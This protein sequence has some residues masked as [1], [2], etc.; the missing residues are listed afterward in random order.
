VVKRIRPTIFDMERVTGFS[1]GTISRAFNQTLPIKAETR[2]FILQKAKEM[3][4]S[5]NSVARNL[6]Q[7]RT[8]RWG[9]LLPHLY[10][11]RFSE[12]M[13]HLDI[14]ARK[15]HSLLLL[16]LSRY[17][18]DIGTK[19]AQHWASGETDGIIADGCVD[20][21]VFEQLH[22]SR[23]P[24]VF[25]YAAPGAQFNVVSTDTSAGFVE[26]MQK[27]IA[28]GHQRIGFI[29]HAFPTRLNHPAQQA[30]EQVL[31]EHHLPI[32]EKLMFFGTRDYTAGAEAWA[33]WRQTRSN[34]TAV[35]CRNDEIACHYIKSA[36]A[37]GFHAPRD[38]SIVG[39]DD[40]YAA[41]LCDLTTLRTDPALM[42]SEAFALLERPYSRTG[43]M[44]LIPAT[45][46]ERHS[47]GPRPAPSHR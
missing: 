43:E 20:A 28:A 16:G 36:Q 10:N 41:A 45:I 7:G 39:S 34:P 35:L 32:E 4:Y 8:N 47:I 6:T 29:N 30:Y 3:G 18:A 46:V 33:Y 24:I 38:F 31:R 13:D 42:A 22:R 9:L 27:L 23:F 5:P 21:T 17:D 1:I 40:T 26:L 25:L 15:R 19:L 11:P 44:R 37:E 14:E 2:N 12:F